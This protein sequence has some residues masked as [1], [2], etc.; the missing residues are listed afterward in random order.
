MNT[1]L[2][3]SGGTG[4]RLPSDVPKQYICVKDK[5]LITYALETLS[6]SPFIDAIQ[7]ISDRNG[8]KR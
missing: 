7:I 1:A 3:L 2:L 5:M 6:V 4:S 8:V